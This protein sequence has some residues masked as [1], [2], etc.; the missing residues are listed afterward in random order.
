[1][2]ARRYKIELIKCLANRIWSICSDPKE[3]DKE[4]SKLRGTLLQNA[5]PPDIVDLELKAFK[6]RKSNASSPP[7]KPDKKRFIVL[8][9]T[10]MRRI[11]IDLGTEKCCVAWL[12]QEKDPFPGTVEIIPNFRNNRTTPSYIAFTRDGCIF[13]GGQGASTL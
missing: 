13:G 5:Y 3:R 11:G 1:M 6:E 2:T 8:P 10:K 9:Y 4:L 12:N 7:P